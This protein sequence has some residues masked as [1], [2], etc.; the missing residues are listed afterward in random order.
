M[1]SALAVLGE[2]LESLSL[3]GLTELSDTTALILSRFK[4][5]FLFIDLDNLPASAAQI[6]RDAG[7][8]E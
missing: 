2:S 7:H 1:F 6:L 4:G 5:E 8:G 3:R